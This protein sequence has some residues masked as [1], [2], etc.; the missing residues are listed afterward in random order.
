[1]STRRAKQIIYGALYL[2]LWA[3]F[4]AAVYGIVWFVAPPAPPAPPCT[5]ATCAPTSTAPLATSTVWTFVTAPQ[6]YTFLAQVA[7]T[8]PDY[9]ATYI[10]YAIDLYDASGT[11]IGSIPENSFVYQGQTKYLVVPNVTVS[12]TFVSAALVMTR[13]YWQASSTLGAVPQFSTENVTAQNGSTT[14]AVGGQLTNANIATTRY[15]V[16]DAIFLGPNGA[17]IGASQTE[18]NNVSPGKTV[19]FSV[20][21][22]Q[23]GSI[24]PS[25][26]TVLVYGLK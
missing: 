26:S 23:T 25:A 20:M 24:D 9:A 13:A 1:M 6:H 12:N 7:D 18:I 15:V 5:E 16:V 19:G 11:V 21:Y 4:I 8:D 22:P 3:A 2:I 14:V 17:P 10:G